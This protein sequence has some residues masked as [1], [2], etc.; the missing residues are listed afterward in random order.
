M[1]RLTVQLAAMPLLLP[2][3][4]PL[5]VRMLLNERRVGTHGTHAV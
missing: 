3:D 5:E 4:Q 1:L 2:L